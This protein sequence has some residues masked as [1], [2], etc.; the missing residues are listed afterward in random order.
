MKLNLR[1]KRIADTDKNR[2][3]VNQELEA[4]DLQTPLG[5]I[6]AV[7]E[8]PEQDVSIRMKVKLDLPGSKVVAE[9]RDYT[10]AAVL[11]KAVVELKR[12]IARRKAKLH[13]VRF[14]P[15]RHSS[16]HA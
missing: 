8:Q 1:F 14:D 10:L 3:L 15:R 16:A 13:A 9:V 6:D 4:L 11:R 2:Q 5:G 12:K 7:V